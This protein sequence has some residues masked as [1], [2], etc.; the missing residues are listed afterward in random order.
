[1]IG[2]NEFGLIALSDKQWIKSIEYL[3]NKDIRLE[4]GIDLNKR[5]NDLY[6]DNVVYRDLMRFL[7]NLI[8]KFSN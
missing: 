2:M 4:L 5:V 7:D 1:M 6:S 3:E 8:T